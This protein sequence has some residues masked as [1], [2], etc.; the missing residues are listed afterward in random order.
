VERASVAP[1]AEG[2]HLD[3]VSLLLRRGF[4]ADKRDRT[5]KATALHWAQP[6]AIP[7]S[8]SVCSRRAPTST[9]RATDT[10]SA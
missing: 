9:A 10:T 2:G 3:C 7:T 5:D 6:A 8:P 4:D 1:A